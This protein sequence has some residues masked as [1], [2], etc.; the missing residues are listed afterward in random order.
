[1]TGIHLLI[2]FRPYLALIPESLFA[3]ALIGGGTALAAGWIAVN[4]TSRARLLAHVTIAHVGLIW[5]ALG[6]GTTMGV[7]AASM[8]LAVHA[9]GMG[10]VCLAVGKTR[11]EKTAYTA[12][13]AGLCGVPL[14]SGFWSL[15]AIL[16]AVRQ[17]GRR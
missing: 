2:V 15:S 1:M 5:L 13:A 9:A 4:Q 7:V 17:C 10:A 11:F 14:L 16:A 3:V 8:H 6:T 12:A